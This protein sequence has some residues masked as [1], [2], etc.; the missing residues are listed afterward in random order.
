MDATVGG[1]QLAEHID[2]SF[3]V[4]AGARD[5]QLIVRSPGVVFDPNSLDL[6]C[7]QHE[8]T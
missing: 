4:L 7:G 2:A 3:R 8:L 5:H 1:E 6:A